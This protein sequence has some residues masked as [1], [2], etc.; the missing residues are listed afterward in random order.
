[1]KQIESLRKKNQSMGD[2]RKIFYTNGNLGKHNSYG[3]STRKW[4]K[5]TYN[6]NE[7]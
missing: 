6:K 4:N 2:V 1:M 5:K 7:R 3:R